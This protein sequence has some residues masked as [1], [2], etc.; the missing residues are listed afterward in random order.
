MFL[1]AYAAAYF[2]IRMPLYISMI[3][4]G[5]LKPISFF[6]CSVFFETAVYFKLFKL[7]F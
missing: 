3:E 7:N 5:L 6:I 4:I 1:V 2:D